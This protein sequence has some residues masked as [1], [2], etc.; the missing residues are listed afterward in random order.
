VKHHGTD[1]KD[2]QRPIL[3]QGAGS[4]G[5]ALC[6]PLLPA[7]REFVINLVGADVVEGKD[8][9]ECADRHEDEDAAI[10]NEV[11]EQAHRY[12]GGDIAGGVECLVTSLAGIKQMV[13]H[14]RR[15]R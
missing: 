11:T 1:Q 12:G 4:D 8:G 10:G 5:L 6:A 7:P 14:V 2:D 15:R 9:R 3:E 13:A